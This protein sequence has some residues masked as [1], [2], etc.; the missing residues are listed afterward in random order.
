MVLEKQVGVIV[1]NAATTDNE[2]TIHTLVKDYVDDAEDVEDIEYTDRGG[3][4]HR[5]DKDTSGV[6]LIARNANSF[7]D[8]QKQFKDRTVEKTYY[9][10][11]HGALKENNI[12]INAPIARNPNKRFKFAVVHSG[13]PAET[14]LEQTATYN[15]EENT[16]SLIKASPKTGR[17]H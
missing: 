11:V 15:W 13:K 8:L 2:L 4:V 14:T 16:F 17:T 1:N 7:H 5:L 3:I 10:I 9:A 6:L 12:L